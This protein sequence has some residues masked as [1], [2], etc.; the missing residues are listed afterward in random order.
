MDSPWRREH[1]A[2]RV[3]GVGGMWAV[4]DSVRLF[5]T[6][7]KGGVGVAPSRALLEAGVKVAAH[8]CRCDHA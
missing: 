5:E 2:C 6:V 3:I 1:A 4:G 7:A 8:V